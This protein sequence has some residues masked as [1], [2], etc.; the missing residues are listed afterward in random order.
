MYHFYGI[1]SL[2]VPIPQRIIISINVEP[3]HMENAVTRVI[4]N[5]SRISVSSINQC[6]K[7][8]LRM[9]KKKPKTACST[10]QSCI[11]AYA[12][13]FAQKSIN[14]PDAKRVFSLFSLIQ[15]QHLEN[16]IPSAKIILS[17]CKT[18]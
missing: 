14:T 9:G 10:I 2:P 1:K 18:A 16:I 4:R 12:Y 11:I 5:L 8:K 7:G 6:I 15:D 13:Q 3:M 17:P